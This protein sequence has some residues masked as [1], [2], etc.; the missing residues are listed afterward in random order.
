MSM[1]RSIK[2]NIIKNALGS[3][4]IKSAWRR[5]QRTGHLNL[6]KLSK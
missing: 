6:K 4:R 3:N 5:Y 1:T 2:R